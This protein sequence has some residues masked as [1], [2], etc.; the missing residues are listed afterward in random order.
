MARLKRDVQSQID[1]MLH[2]REAYAAGFR[3][4]AGIDEAGRGPLAGPV[5][6]ACVVLSIEDPIDGVDDSKA[7]TASKRES[8][9]IEIIA[10]SMAYGIA[11]IDADTIDQINILQATL[12]AMRTAH[13]NILHKICP[14]LVLIDG[15][16]L[17][18]IVNVHERALVGGDAKSA[19]IAAASILAKVTRDRLMIE[20]AKTYPHYGFDSHKGYGCP[21]HLAALRDHGPC[22]LHRKSF[23]PVS[24]TA[25]DFSV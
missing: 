13:A 2:E 21:Q 22:P 10:R 11:I 7:L 15:N 23:S 3:C 18:K 16:T 14:D 25:L 12:L 24:Q 6:A 1:L 9:Y 8:C 17:P 19:S 4:V 5:V 20:A